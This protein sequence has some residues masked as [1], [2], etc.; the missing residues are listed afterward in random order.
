VIELQSWLFAGEYVTCRVQ[1]TINIRH[2]MVRDSSAALMI[3]G[4]LSLDRAD[5][6]LFLEA[7]DLQYAKPRHWRRFTR[8][9]IGEELR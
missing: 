7:R 5:F 1:K 9:Y 8:E 2:R 4:D 3:G 6:P